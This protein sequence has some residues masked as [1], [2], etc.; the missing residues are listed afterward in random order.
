MIIA[1]DFDETYNRAPDLFDDILD[2][3]RLH[4]HQVIMATYRHPVEDW[5]PLFDRLSEQKIPLY[6]TDGKA[7]GPWLEERGIKV[8]IWFD[9]NP[10]AVLQ[11]SAWKH[12]SPELHAWREE[13]K[14][15]LA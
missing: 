7:K 6:C 2:V 3:I 9:D 15:R 4:G 1:Y 8:D 5:D 12:D 13:N 11:D 14:K 10:K